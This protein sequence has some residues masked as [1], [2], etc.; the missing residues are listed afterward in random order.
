MQ[1]GV[2]NKMKP[3]HIFDLYLYK[4]FIGSLQEAKIHRIKGYLRFSR[5]GKTAR[6]RN[7][8]VVLDTRRRRHVLYLYPVWVPA[9]D[10]I[11]GEIRKYYAEWWVDG[12]PVA[13]LDIEGDML[14][15][16][17]GVLDALI[18]PY[19]ADNGKF[20]IYLHEEPRTIIIE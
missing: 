8:M 18:T 11:G 13:I 12:E 5:S 15:Y 3:I 6:I 9:D 4:K 14:G 1:N 10:E 2:I 17:Y 20:D 7:L 19:S 16:I